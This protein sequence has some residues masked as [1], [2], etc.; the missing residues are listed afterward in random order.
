MQN[1]AT[2]HRLLAR[3]CET[4]AGCVLAVGSGARMQRSS[5]W[6][7]PAE[8]HRLC[9]SERSSLRGVAGVE[10]PSADLQPALGG[11]GAAVAQES[12]EGG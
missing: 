6:P 2:A 11:V 12:G 4:V 8:Q 10:R 9:S 5:P 7:L 1:R 3:K